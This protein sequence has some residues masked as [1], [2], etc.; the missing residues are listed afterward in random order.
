[1]GD[2]RAQPRHVHWT[3]RHFDAPSSCLEAR[4]GSCA[5]RLA[6]VQCR[7]GRA[8][9]HCADRRIGARHHVNRR[10]EEASTISSHRATA[11]DAKSLL[12]GRLGGDRPLAAAN[13]HGDERSARDGPQPG[14]SSAHNAVSHGRAALAHHPVPVRERR[15]DG[16]HRHA[17][18]AI[19]GAHGCCGR[20]AAVRLGCGCE[21]TGAPSCSAHRDVPPEN[22]RPLGLVC[23]CNGFGGLLGR[24]TLQR[25]Y[26]ANL[27]RL[28][29]SLN[30]CNGNVRRD[31]ISDLH[32]STAARLR[33]GVDGAEARYHFPPPNVP[34]G[35][36]QRDGNRASLSY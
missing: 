34:Q 14:R 19:S 7:A 9:A 22:Y 16:L 13:C 1:M 26:D 15:A 10:V 11:R 24:L 2:H 30:E 20:G 6:D 31:R 17:G 18:R 23:S 25:A 21:K 35:E 12:F 32:E 5:D 8:W 36:R 27:L 29:G 4:R 33:S 28:T 3:V